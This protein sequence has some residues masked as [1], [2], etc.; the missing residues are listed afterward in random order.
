MTAA[1]ETTSAAAPLASGQSAAAPNANGAGTG[2]RRNEAEEEINNTLGQLLLGGS[3]GE[4]QGLLKTLAD[5]ADDAE[6]KK[7][8]R[9]SSSGGSAAGREEA[10]SVA[11]A[12]GDIVRAEGA[13]GSLESRLDALLGRLDGLLAT[14][15]EAEGT[16]KQPPV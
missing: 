10:E 15:Q 3:V 16:A 8:S 5:K 2:R 13:V 1:K 14:Q 11:D 9:K 6:E 4:I 7:K 12:Y